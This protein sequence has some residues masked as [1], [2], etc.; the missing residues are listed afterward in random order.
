MRSHPSRQVTAKKQLVKKI[1]RHHLGAPAK[2]VL[3]KPE[4]KTNFVFEAEC[5]GDQYI[6]R[7]GGTQNKINDYIKEQWAVERAARQG[8]PVAEILEVGNEVVPLPYMLQR[9]LDGGDATNHPDRKKILKAL[10]GLSRK[11]HSIATEQFGNVFDWSK[12]QLS[13]NRSWQSFLH[14]EWQIRNRLSILKRHRLLE[15]NQV[16]LLESVVKKMEKLNLPPALNHGD[17]RLKNVIIDDKGK[18]RAIID[19]EHCI[20][21]IAP[22]WDLSI[23][24][25][26]LPIDAKQDFL[27]GYGISPSAYTGMAPLIKTFN[28]LN[29]IPE[30]E[31]MVREKD[32]D[33]LAFYRLRLNGHFDLYKL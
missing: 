31:R 13:K 17:L 2:A 3:F 32:K 4:G 33:G 19:W 30:I 16:R 7:I 1:I 18:I 14:E 10:G 29:Y 5:R 12:N 8:V 24:L 25:H 26:D 27:E 20:S 15:K 6:V 21:S 9:K 23:A 11:I 22:L 28:I